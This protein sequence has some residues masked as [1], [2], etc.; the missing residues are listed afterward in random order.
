MIG[1]D[2]YYVVTL[3]EKFWRNS[4]PEM[5]GTHDYKLAEASYGMR[6]DGSWEFNYRIQPKN[7]EEYRDVKLLVN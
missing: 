4:V 3:F 7:T 6:D 2:G 5:L 1:I